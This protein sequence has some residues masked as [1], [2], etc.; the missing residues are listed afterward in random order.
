MKETNPNIYAQFYIYERKT[1]FPFLLEF[2]VSLCGDEGVWNY[3]GL[4]KAGVK[5]AKKKT[6]TDI[7]SH[8]RKTY[9]DGINRLEISGKGI[10]KLLP[11]ELENIKMTIEPSPLNEDWAAI[12]KFDF[13]DYTRPVGKELFSLGTREGYVFFN[14]LKRDPVSIF[15]EIRL[16]DETQKISSDNMIELFS[17]FFTMIGNKYVEGYIGYIDNG[18]S[19][20]ARTRMVG[21]EKKKA[22][23]MD[24]N[25]DKPHMAIFG[26]SKVIQRYVADV[27]NAYLDIN[28]ITETF[29]SASIVAFKN[30]AEVKE[31]NM[32]EWHQ[33]HP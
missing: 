30:K 15:I 21:T 17:G 14:R 32:P 9:P 3:K 25:F 7:F 12:E 18:Y 1:L 26:S 22:V 29:G 11:E 31:I 5:K 16:V 33:C 28:M 6:L 13:V 20:N 8:F 4:S 19:F 27:R 23:R 10:R 2:L 24:E